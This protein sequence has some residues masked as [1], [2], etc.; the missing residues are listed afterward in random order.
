VYFVQLSG[1]GVYD[2]ESCPVS[3]RFSCHFIMEAAAMNSTS[4]CS[5]AL[6]LAIFL[7]LYFWDKS[8]HDYSNRRNESYYVVPYP[9]HYTQIEL[10][11]IY[12]WLY[13]KL[14]DCGFKKNRSIMFEETQITWTCTLRMTG[15][16]DVWVSMRF[17]LI[18]IS[19]KEKQK[20]PCWPG[21]LLTSFKSP[22]RLTIHLLV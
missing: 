3:C 1:T 10:F 2:K 11:S 7:P 17:G 8:I 14:L 16:Y 20:E 22:N 4:I 6:R 9:Y 12:Y 18:V 19:K 13:I 21:S 15:W 5:H